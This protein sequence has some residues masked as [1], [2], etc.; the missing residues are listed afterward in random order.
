[1]GRGDFLLPFIFA[2]KK[3]SD[4]PY[5]IVI[6]CADHDSEIRAK[7]FLAEQVSRAVIKSKSAQK[8]AIELNYE[9]RLKDD[10]TDFINIL[11]EMQGI[12]S[13]VLVSYNGDYLG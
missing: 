12:N 7:E 4:N 11:S 10:N 1:L 6:N 3:S 13:A 8:G 2:N 5:I 9:I